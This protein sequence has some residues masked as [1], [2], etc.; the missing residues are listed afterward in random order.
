MKNQLKIQLD[1]L[2]NEVPAEPQCA[3]SDSFPLAVTSSQP[4]GGSGRALYI[5]QEKDTL[6][7]KKSIVNEINNYSEK[8]QIAGL[9]GMIQKLKKDYSL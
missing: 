2:K 8:I 6:D 9:R 7:I 1:I 4:P 5:C 3:L